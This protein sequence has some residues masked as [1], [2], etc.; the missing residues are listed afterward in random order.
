MLA[1]VL[2]AAM[3]VTPAPHRAV[4]V[5]EGFDAC[6]TQ[7]T[8]TMR[9]WLGSPYRAVNFY[10]PTAAG[11]AKACQDQPELTAQWVSTVTANGW[12]L[13]PT[14]V[15]L[16]P[17]CTNGNKPRFN[18]TNA[19]AS[20]TAAA[21]DAVA[22]VAGLGIGT[23][24]PVYVDFEP[25]DVGN[26][27]CTQA[28][29]DFVSAWVSEM[30]AQHYTAGLYAHYSMGLVPLR[31]QTSPKPDDIWWA[32]YDNVDST[33]GE[34]AVGASYPGHRI[35]QY[36][37]QT[38]S[39]HSTYNGQ[40]IQIDNDAVHADVVGTVRPPVASGPDY[41]YQAA[42]P[43]G[44]TLKQRS[45]PSPNDTQV[46]TYNYGDA[47]SIACQ[48]VG[49]TIH[50]TYV[51]DQLTNLSYVTDLYTTTTG[52]L[53]FTPGIPKCDT[54]PPTTPSLSAVPVATLY[55]GQTFTWSASSDVDSGIASY[56]LRWHTARWS[57]GFGSW[58]RVSQLTSRQ[59]RLAL[60]SGYDYCV[61]VRAT[62]RSGNAGAWSAP[63]CIARALDDRALTAG[64]RWTRDTG[65]NFF[66]R[67]ATTTTS[68][69]A[70][71]SRPKAQ[72]VRVGVVAT[73]CPSCGSVDVY[74]GKHFAGS[75]SLQATSKRLRSVQMLP[76]FSLRS[77][78]VSLIVTSTG[79]RVQIDG[80]VISR[81]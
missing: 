11:L 49:D 69:H 42:P 48:A 24:N 10:I 61:E 26:A 47:I 7:D 60:A 80:L 65:R 34:P 38:G 18:A 17:P 58:H 29:V 79:K 32:R 50:G 76:P 74:V 77:R 22:Y 4:Y 67:T 46:G 52:G 21:D 41:V 19:S 36:F 66:L 15:G 81:T 45:G 40:S 28:A 14:Y 31:T 44:V 72:L 3:A 51:W 70:S 39:L 23:G 62:D 63:G 33:S 20:G 73:R 16:Q 1:V 56:D 30:H 68:H 25:F 2:A 6:H 43:V 78:T 12:S 57:G 27:H 37:S 53:S 5:G 59:L 54:S 64:P 8:G 9:A 13:I 35:H 71:M 55:S 75:V